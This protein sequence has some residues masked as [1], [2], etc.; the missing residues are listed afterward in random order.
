[1][2]P[3]QIAA[4]TPAFTAYLQMFF[5]CCDYVATFYLLT[6]Y[7]RG[8]L[9]DLKRKTCEPIALEAGIAVRTLQ[10]F[11][12]DHVWSFQQTR[13][14]HQQHVA[15]DLPNHTTDDLGTIGLIDET[16]IVKKGTKTPGV[17]R[18]WCGERGKKENCIVTVHLGV[19]RG[20]FK[21]LVDAD[22]FLPDVW[23]KDRERCRA[24]GIPDDLHHRPKWQIALE[25]LDRAGC[26]GLTVDWLTF[27]EGYGQAPEFLTG[28]DSRQ[29]RFVCEVPKSFR[30]FACWPRRR[31]AGRRADNLVRH[32][33]T[34]YSQR[35]RR[36]RLQRQTLGPQEW[37]V[38]AGQVW[39]SLD[40]RPSGRTYWLIWAR[41][42]RTGEEK[43][44]VSNAPPRTSLGRLLRVG[45]SRWNVE[46][47]FR[48]C[49]SELGFRHF[50]GRNY[51]A[52]MR[53]MVL[54]CVTLTFVAGQTDRL[55]GEKSRDDDGAGVRG[56]EPTVRG[57]AGG[58]AGDEPVAEQVSGHFLSPAA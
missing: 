41:N 25:Q 31:Q 55:R 42:V 40:G 16:G 35:W 43:Y 51:V 7:C 47:C 57:V 8:L 58:L 10:E 45:F 30:C 18:Q 4:L 39:L 33:P 12:K 3:A 46:H 1:M 29:Q 15:A 2:T 6:V 44:F 54:C 48:V 26:N 27:D 38:K 13:S 9:S 20:R 24:A 53:H 28:L 21:T 22:L 11:L 17:Q 52:L 56:A 50:E 49:K 32:S 37:D 5:F 23:D 34:F 36:F 14:T 19:A